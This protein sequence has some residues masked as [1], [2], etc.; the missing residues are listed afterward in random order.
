MYNCNNSHLQTTHGNRHITEKY[1]TNGINITVFNSFSISS[2]M[3][4][5]LNSAA[6]AEVGEAC[7]R[8]PCL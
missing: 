5:D 2:K 8:A 1:L 3:T 4:L 6:S 7:K